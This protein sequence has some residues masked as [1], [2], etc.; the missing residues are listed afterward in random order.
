MVF[1]QSDE[2]FYDD[3]DV[4]SVTFTGTLII[5]LV[6]LFELNMFFFIITF[7]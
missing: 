2:C 1:L 7:K 6:L 4:E 3:E 5:H